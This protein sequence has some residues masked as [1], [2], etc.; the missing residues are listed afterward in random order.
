MGQEIAHGRD[1]TLDP[2]QSAC[3]GEA[4]P[5]RATFAGLALG[6]LGVVF[7]DIGTS[8]L[9]A[10]RESLTH[11]RT[12]GATDTGVIGTVS[13]LMWA[14]FFTVT[15]KYVLFLMQADNRGEGGILSL[16]ALAQRAVGRA[17]S[18]VFFLGV[19]GAA[20]FSGD[21]VITPAISVLSAIEG[22]ELVTPIF[23]PY[24][25]PITIAILLSL[26][27]TQRHGTARVAAFFGPI[28][29]VFFLVIG[30]LGAIHI[31]DAPRILQAFNPLIGLRFLFQHGLLGFVVLGSV[32]LA[33][34]GA[35]ALYADMG[36]FGRAPIQSVWV[37]FVLPALSLNYLGQ[38]AL[39]LA[40]PESMANPF[41]LLAPH[42]A[43]LPL[44]ILATIATIIASQAVITGAFSLVRQ[45]IQLGLLPRMLILHTS[46]TL[47]GRIFLPRINRLLLIGVLV[48]VFLFRSSS[49][50]ASAY[51]VAVTGT[52]VATTALAFMVIWKCWH[53]PV[54]LAGLFISGFL[55]IDVAFLTANLLK[56][57][58]GGW[59][60]L[61]LAGCSMIIMWTW[62][63]G[64]WL[65]TQKLRR[66]SI[67]TPDLIRLL[68]KS[69]PMRVTGTAVFLTSSPEIAP[70]ALMHNLKHNKVLHERVWLLSVLTENTP[71]VPAN[72][73]Y[74][75]EKL[76]DDFTRVILHYGYMESPRV[77]AA[78]ASLRKAGLKFDIMTTSFFL[79][80]WTI[81]PAANSA[82]PAWQDQ[83]FITLSRQAANATDFFSIPSD[84]VV[85]LGAQVTV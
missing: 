59:V 58:D 10:L 27:W 81:K 17:I 42:W 31:G 64:T 72:K 57:V 6:S 22:L 32:F 1:P 30:A 5:R 46:E 75:I 47:E 26:F 69:K 82:M 9:Y 35:E 63:R 56:I 13:L 60:P 70:S 7:G 62:V 54:W 11:I 49:S 33:V 74:E 37:L 15:A 38:G 78:L 68:E 51:G 16:M 23:S 48:L 83:L 34:T 2:P 20:L 19:A 40:Y 29:A 39:V 67:P 8:P 3:A 36:H 52:M 73:R 14:L 45:A 77:P 25:L 53:W 4:T 66:D 28:M 12:A 24:I 44:V 80:R 43:L 21:A 85:E 18:P 41:F 79:G 84:R 55:A 71:R 61:L 76:S 65:F 50:L